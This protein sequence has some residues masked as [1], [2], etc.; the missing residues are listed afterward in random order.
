[1]QLRRVSTPLVFPHRSSPPE[2]AI[3]LRSPASRPSCDP[4][5]QRRIASQ[6]VSVANRS[7]PSL[8]LSLFLFLFLAVRLY[9]SRPMCRTLSSSPRSTTTNTSIPAQ[10][11]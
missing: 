8:L 7:C 6:I 3:S 1:M 5:S 11:Q 2:D 9:A 10:A 4:A